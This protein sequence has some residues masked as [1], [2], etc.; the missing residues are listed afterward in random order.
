MTAQWDVRAEDL[1]ADILIASDGDRAAVHA[2][3]KVSELF[4]EAHSFTILTVVG[5]SNTPFLDGATIDDH[6]R[7]IEGEAE[8]EMGATVQALRKPVRIRVEHGDPAQ[9]IVSVAEHE[10]VDLVVIGAHRAHPLGRLLHRSV[11]KY[12]ADHVSCPVLIV[13]MV[14]AE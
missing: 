13:P 10:G 3:E 12:V 2:A 9:R 7:L 8:I 1:V 14:D 5:D 11:T 4:D 6:H